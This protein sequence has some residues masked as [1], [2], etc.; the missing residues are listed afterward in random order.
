M[1]KPYSYLGDELDEMGEYE[2]LKKL[3][4]E[5]KVFLDVYFADIVVKK[6]TVNQYVRNVLE[7][8]YYV[9]CAQAALGL[10]QLDEAEKRW[11]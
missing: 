8:Y 1:P 6:K 7:S 11:R 4:E 2:K 5:W 9:A 3:T 10:N